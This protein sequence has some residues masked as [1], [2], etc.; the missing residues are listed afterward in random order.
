MDNYIKK[1]ERLD[2][3][4]I[5]GLKIIQDPRKFCFGID[6]VLLANYATVKKGDKVVDLGTGT[7]IIPLIIAGKTEASVITGIEIQKDMAQMA[8]RS[9]AMNGLEDRIKIIAGDLKDVASFAAPGTADLAVSNPPYMIDGH[10]LI[11]PNSSKA[12]ARHEIMC[13]FEDVARSAAK[14]LKNGG[15]FALIHRSNRMVDI[16]LTMRKEGIEPKRLCM[17]HPGIDKEA[18]LFLVEGIKGAGRFLKVS[19]PLIV[20]NK[21]GEYTERIRRIYYEGE[22]L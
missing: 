15:R 11:N 17:V 9:V 21:E 7:G 12:I 16:L 10:G 2:D 13:T 18:N 5:G 6:A 1:G 4:D 8:E 20:Y 14:V 19:K 3:L 22:R